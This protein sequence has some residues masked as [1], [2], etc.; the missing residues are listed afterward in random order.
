MFIGVYYCHMHEQGNYILY[1]QQ[2]GF[3]KNHS[4]YLAINALVTIFHESVENSE[5]L[6][7]L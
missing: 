4:T 6:V 3:R 7:Y 1:N 5:F 2:F